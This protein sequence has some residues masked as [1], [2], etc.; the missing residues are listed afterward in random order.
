M[1]FYNQ[2]NFQVVNLYDCSLGDI[3]HWAQICAEYSSSVYIDQYNDKNDYSALPGAN[4]NEFRAVQL[5][6]GAIDLLHSTW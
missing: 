6:T 5:T 4:G 3:L 2:S 1:V